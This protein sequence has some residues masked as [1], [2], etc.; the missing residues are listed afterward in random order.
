MRRQAE[1]L[2]V[3][4]RIPSTGEE[5]HPQRMIEAI[6]GRDGKIVGMIRGEW[7]RSEALEMLRELVLVRDEAKRVQILSEFVGE[8]TRPPCMQEE[9]DAQRRIRWDMRDVFG[10]AEG[11]AG[12]LAREVSTSAAWVK[13]GRK[14][15]EALI[16][17]LE[18]GIATNLR[19]DSQWKMGFL[20]YFASA[21]YLSIWGKL[22]GVRVVRDDEE[23]EDE[24]Q[25]RHSPSLMRLLLQV[26]E[27]FERT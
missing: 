24:E 10:E 7:I 6:P 20:G 14:Y 23:D 12:Y 13:W 16:Y 21:R 4:L 26:S 22:V 3:T 8:H 17:A 9:C 11:K 18:L 15:I 2:T 25:L 5:L 27:G 1:E 19:W